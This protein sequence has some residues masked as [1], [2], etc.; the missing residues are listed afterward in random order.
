MATIG[1]GLAVSLLSGTAEAADTYLYYNN[2]FISSSE[3]S[4]FRAAMT[5]MGATITSTS[6]TSYPTSY[7]GYDLVIFLL[8]DRTFNGTQANALKSFVEGGGRLVVSGDWASGGS[9]FST[10][11]NY[12]NTLLTQIGSSAQ[13]TNTIVGSGCN[14]TSSYSS[15]TITDGVSSNLWIAA[16]T[17][18]SGSAPPSGGGWR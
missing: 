9:G 15:D 13:L 14:A 12:V 18:C 17:T 1:L 5:G 6:S 16:S 3:L 11:N 2:R 10:Y 4:D 8:P 7:A